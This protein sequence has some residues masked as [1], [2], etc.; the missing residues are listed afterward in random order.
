MSVPTEG[1]VN[2]EERGGGLHQK[3][4]Q[5][6]HR[7]T[8]MSLSRSNQQKKEIRRFYKILSP[9]FVCLFFIWRRVTCLVRRNS[10]LN[11][12]PTTKIRSGSVLDFRIEIKCQKGLLSSTCLVG[13]GSTNTGVKPEHQTPS[14]CQYLSESGRFRGMFYRN[15]GKTGWSVR[16]ILP[17]VPGPTNPRG[18]KLSVGTLKDEQLRFDTL[19]TSSMT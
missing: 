10:F 18:P 6:W 9:V 16:V 15:S 1:T 5:C 7:T 13:V 3:R 12:L 17:I 14:T 19:K 11:A 8:L 4:S 2:R